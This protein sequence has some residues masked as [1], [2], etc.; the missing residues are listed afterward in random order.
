MA[1]AFELKE[2]GILTEKDFEG[3]PIDNEGKFYW[4]LDKIVRREG[5]GDVLANGVYAAARK[6]GKGAEAFDHNTIKKHEQL[7]LKLGMLNPGYFLMYATGEKIN[8]TQI[9]GSSRNRLSR[10]WKSGKIFV[11]D[12]IQVPD[13]KV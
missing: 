4:L 13:G 6:I 3:C 2:A 10:Q 7:P 8:I 1:F 9:E 12:W 5:I 11:K